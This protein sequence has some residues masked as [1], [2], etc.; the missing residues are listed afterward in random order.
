MGL[1]YAFLTQIPSHEASWDWYLLKCEGLC[2]SLM[3]PRPRLFP[4]ARFMWLIS[5]IESYGS[6]TPAGHCCDQAPSK[7]R[8]VECF[9]GAVFKWS[10]VLSFTYCD[11]FSPES[12]ALHCLTNI[13]CCVILFATLFTV[14]SLT[15]ELCVWAKRIKPRRKRLNE[16][17]TIKEM[18]SLNCR[19]WSTKSP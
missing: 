9:L 7:I 4:T 13:S 5:S 11:P 15:I 3:T 17:T 10:D 14:Q 2:N 19:L 16:V 1:Q 8:G 12:G 6:E 18:N